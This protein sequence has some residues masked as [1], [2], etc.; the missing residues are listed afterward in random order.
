MLLCF[1]SSIS[2]QEDGFAYIDV[3]SGESLKRLNH[4]RRL[5]PL[6]NRN[7]ELRYYSLETDQ[8]APVNLIF[9]RMLQP[10]IA[11]GEAELAMNNLSSTISFLTRLYRLN[12]ILF[13]ESHDLVT[14]YADH[15]C[16]HIIQLDHA[17][18]LLRVG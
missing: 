8:P 3:C 1:S 11:C 17:S 12:C 2:R 10:V 5:G 4:L 16:D 13:P 9:H 6:R 15:C 14:K 18:G 7:N